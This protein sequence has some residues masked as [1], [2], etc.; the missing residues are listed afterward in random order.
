MPLKLPRATLSAASNN[1]KPDNNSAREADV[2]LKLPRAMLSA[3]SQSNALLKE[4]NADQS[5]EPVN[6][7][8]SV[9]PARSPVRPPRTSEEKENYGR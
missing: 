5:N 2:P 4:R 6:K 3:A 9:H 7:E 1:A 8:A